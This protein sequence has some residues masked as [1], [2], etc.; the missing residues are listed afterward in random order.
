MIKFGLLFISCKGET[1]RKKSQQ[2][3]KYI[4]RIKRYLQKQTLIFSY[5]LQEKEKDEKKV[6]TL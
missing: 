4:K 5:S 1:A 6:T 2:S 3:K